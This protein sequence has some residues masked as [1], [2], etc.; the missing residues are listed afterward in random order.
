V[1]TFPVLIFTL[2][3]LPARSVLERACQDVEPAGRLHTH[4]G[5]DNDEQDAELFA[6]SGPRRPWSALWPRFRR[7]G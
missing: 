4:L 2:P 6:C 7:L 3:L 1:L 5:I